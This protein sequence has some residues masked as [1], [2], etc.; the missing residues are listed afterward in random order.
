MQI[1]PTN[2][3]SDRGDRRG[4]AVV[5]VDRTEGPSAVSG[6]RWLRPPGS[7]DGGCHPVLPRD[8]EAAADLECAALDRPGRAVLVHDAHGRLV[9]STVPLGELTGLDGLSS[10]GRRGWVLPDGW[11][12][13][14]VDGRPLAA[15]DLPRAR[16]M[17][18]GREQV[19]VAVG[20]QAPDGAVR[21]LRVTA[22]PVLGDGPEPVAVVSAVADAEGP[23]G[24]GGGAIGT[25]EA[26][27]ELA[28]ATEEVARAVLVVDEHGTVVHLDDGAQRLYGVDASACGRAAVDVATWDLPRRRVAELLA[29]R[30]TSW[31]G[32]VWARRGG[33]V[34]VPVHLTVAPI[35]GADGRGLTV[36]VAVEVARRGASTD[37]LV[38]ERL[39]D[40]L[41]G[42]PD[43][44]LFF[45]GVRRTV[46]RHD[47]RRGP[48]A[49]AMLDLDDFHVINDAFGHAAGDLVIAHAGR[50]LAAVAH[51]ADVVARL[52][53][54]TFAV[55]CTHLGRHA[56]VGA[57]ADR[58]REAV[59][60]TL[61]AGC[62]D[63][64]VRW[65]AGIATSTAV[66]VGGAPPQYTSPSMN[67][68]TVPSTT[69]TSRRRASGFSEKTNRTSRSVVQST[70]GVLSWHGLS[71]RNSA[72]IRYSAVYRST[73]SVSVQ[74]SDQ[75]SCRHAT[76]SAPSGV[77][78]RSQTSLPRAPSTS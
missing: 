19:G 10:D 16:A 21:W 22:R 36:A 3:I 38:D 57:Y 24:A 55:C 28:A 70:S 77:A 71:D 61:P 76:L 42:L 23:T 37:A 4:L 11:R 65:S 41:T 63:Q 78:H 62:P 7:V 14:G 54:A 33:G 43:R 8:V 2:T 25:A 6:P 52:S 48:V 67:A 60:G 13:V 47:H 26:L 12:L 64:P 31:S 49:V 1:G 18:T 32:R 51:K 45:E 68:V 69:A 20:L 44:R 56:D 9:R 39:H 35:V 46:A 74:L 5:G 59:S 73:K 15:G 27:D 75:G 40:D 29:D 34:A 50:A 58:L 30:E 72:S 66:D 53:G 17:R